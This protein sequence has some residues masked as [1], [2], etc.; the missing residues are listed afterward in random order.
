MRTR[1]P[2]R[3]H[4]TAVDACHCAQTVTTTAVA[5]TTQSRRTGTR[6]GDR[7]G[8][9]TC[10]VTQHCGDE[11]EQAL[12][13]VDWTA[14]GA[15][16]AVVIGAV[17]QL[18][19]VRS[20]REGQDAYN[21][22]LDAIGHNHSG[23]LHDGAGPAAAILAAVVHASQARRPGLRSSSTTRP[24]ELIDRPQPR[25]PQPEYVGQPPLRAT[26]HVL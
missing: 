20:E 25:S 11:I 3:V 14:Y 10:L 9:H 8:S 7:R 6:A 19:L 1:R 24:A 4:C 16:P 2:C 23:R 5:H 12:R 15:D 17:R 13:A 21:E 18:R 26:A 22:V